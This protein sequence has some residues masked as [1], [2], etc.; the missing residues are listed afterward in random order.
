MCGGQTAASIGL[1]SDPGRGIISNL[2]NPLLRLAARASSTVS[3]LI[4][5]SS[6]AAFSDVRSQGCRFEPCRV[7]RVDIKDI[8]I[9][10]LIQNAANVPVSSSF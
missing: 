2:K 3:L 10:S 6:L 7:Q 9:K 8:K 4:R 5:Q 1:G